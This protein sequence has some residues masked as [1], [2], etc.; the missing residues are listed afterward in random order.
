MEQPITITDLSYDSLSN[1]THAFVEIP[2]FSQWFWISGKLNETQFKRIIS[3]TVQRLAAEV[4][5]A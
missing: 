5:I 3:P 2:E 4:R 1:K